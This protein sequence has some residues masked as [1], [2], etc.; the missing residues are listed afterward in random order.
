MKLPTIFLREECIL[1]DRFDLPREP[2]CEGWTAVN[3]VLVSE[4]DISIR[5]AD[6]HF[7]WLTDSHSARGIGK[8]PETAI[9]R[10]LIRAL[11]EMNQ[12]FNAAEVGL[13]ESTNFLGLRVAKVTLD[14][15]HIQKHTSLESVEES[16]L[17]EVL[18]L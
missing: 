9:H 5:S 15:R 4:L 1:P 7:L 14:T 10:A 16:R 12:S 18:A 17:K 6:W 11:R 2:F 13:F 8:T 3:G